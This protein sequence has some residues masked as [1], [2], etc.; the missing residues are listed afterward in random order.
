[1]KLIYLANIRIPTQRAHGY[2]IMK[3]CEELARQGVEMELVIPNKKNNLGV[4]PFD[5]YGLDRNFKIT[6]LAAMDFLGRLPFA[7]WLFFWLDSIIFNLAL[8]RKS[9]LKFSNNIYTRDY[10]IAALLPKRCRIFLE[11]HDLPKSNFLLKRALAKSAG[12]L[13]ISGGLKDDLEKRGLAMAEIKILPDAVDLERFDIKISQAEARQKLNLP[14]DKK[15]ILYGGHLYGW[16]GADILA[17]AAGSLPDCLIVFVGGIDEERLKFEREYGRAANIKIISFQKR[18]LMPFYFKAA[19][20]L[21]LPNKKGDL[22]S[23]KYT[24]PLKLFEYMAVGRPIV[25]SDLPSIREILNESNAV[26]V[27]S[28][29]P[30]ELAEGIKKV[31]SNKELADRISKQ[32][33]KDVESYTWE[34]RAEN[35]TRFIG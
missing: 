8:R 7:N 1:M 4:D 15:I 9:Y 18:E 17:Q 10:F 26:L 23:E 31:L 22:I 24:S 13:V 25:A 19:D 20:I 11:L 12:I 33:L 6:R 16:K 14:S 2:A 34:K 28:S 21:V 30:H 3:M 27:E 29:N 35:I 32:A 5:Y